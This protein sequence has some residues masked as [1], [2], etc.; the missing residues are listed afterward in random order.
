[1]GS[2][3]PLVAHAPLVL[4]PVATLF[5]AFDFLVPASRLRLAAL[6]LLA[7]GFAG[8][9]IA[10][11][12]GGP[13]RHQDLLT[14]PGLR[15][16]PA[17]GLIPK[18]VGNGTLMGTHSALAQLTE[19]LYGGL[20]AVELAMLFLTMPRFRAYSRGIALTCVQERVLRGVWIGIAVVG[21]GLVVLTG[22]YGGA[23]VYDHGVGVQTS[24]SPP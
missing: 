18:L 14:I 13:A 16:I 23:L 15:S 3:H 19:L 12:T 4:L 11:Q 21:I 2:W 20:L 9:F 6:F 7:L 22:H 24:V 8:A 1:M 17:S 5:A 10:V